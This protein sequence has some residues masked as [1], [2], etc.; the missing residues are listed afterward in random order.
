MDNV[1]VLLI[2]P[3]ETDRRAMASIFTR[4][5]WSLA[6]VSGLGE[7]QQLLRRQT[8]SIIV[9]ETTFPGGDWRLVLSTA[10]VLQPVPPKVIVASRL[11]DD[12]LWQHVLDAGGY[13]LL[14]K[15]F[16]PESIFWTVSQAWRHWRAECA[17]ALQR[18][19]PGYESREAPLPVEE[20]MVALAAS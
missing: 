10:S 4:S 14:E 18:L 2:S 5:R 8:P 13:D 20:P 11:A 3:F 9:T 15:P 7:A 16:E 17:R 19:G 1:S 12:A 6:A